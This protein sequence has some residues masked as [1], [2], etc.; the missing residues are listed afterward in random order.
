MAQTFP[1][2]QEPEVLVRPAR[3]EDR[4]A[5]LAF[6]AHT[7]SD[8]DYIEN[9]WDE[10]LGSPRGVLLVAVVGERPVGIVHVRMVSDD[11]AWMEGMRVDPD[12]RRRGIGRVLS[13][14]ALAAAHERGA[15]VARLMTAHDNRASQALAAAFGYQR[16]AEVARYEAAAAL[17]AEP[18]PTEGAA[19]PLARDEETPLRTPDESTF[20][21]IWAWLAQSNLAPLT[22]GLEFTWWAARALVEPRLRDYLASGQVVTLEGW[23]TILALAILHDAPARTGEVATLQVRYV[24]GQAE[25]IGR[26][27]RALRGVAAARGLARV[28]LWL[29]DLLIL[30]D[31]MDGAGYQRTYSGMWV[32]QREL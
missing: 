23:D 31:A 24:D 20:E 3:P 18:T 15:T 9:V 13:S 4:A 17:T 5:V 21:R 10:W 8:G 32:Y 26:L 27:A 6:C 19:P 16:I 2:G 12:A 25:S 11:E 14:R 30:H 29:P 7:W 22:G 28:D 1:A